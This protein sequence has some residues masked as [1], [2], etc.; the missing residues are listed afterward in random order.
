MPNKTK[1]GLEK[2][3]LLTAAA[4][5]AHMG[6]NISKQPKPLTKINEE[7]MPALNIKQQYPINVNNFKAVGLKK[8]NNSQKTGFKPKSHTFEVPLLETT[9]TS[10]TRRRRSRRSIQKKN[11]ISKVNSVKGRGNNKSKK[12]AAP[13]AFQRKK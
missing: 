4:T 6:P 11:F 13:S 7:T 2:L 8:K 12:R 5:A 10:R 3:S 1:K 9:N